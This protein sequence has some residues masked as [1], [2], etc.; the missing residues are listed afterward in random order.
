MPALAT[1]K[2]VT[3][4]IYS[5]AGMVSTSE[6]GPSVGDATQ[7]VVPMTVSQAPTTG[8]GGCDMRDPALVRLEKHIMQE[9]EK[10]AEKGIRED[11]IIKGN[12]GVFRFN[13]NQ[14]AFIIEKASG[15]GERSHTRTRVER[16]LQKIQEADGGW[17]PGSKPQYFKRS[18]SVVGKPCIQ[19][20]A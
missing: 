20:S 13:V 16:G 12:D 11:Y 19:S 5:V 7:A 18:R 2:I 10:L 6:P 14:C 1:Q 17:V 4:S 8:N 9:L 15:D 3:N